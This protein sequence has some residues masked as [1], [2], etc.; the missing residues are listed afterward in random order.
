MVKTEKQKKIGKFRKKRVNSLKKN[1]RFIGGDDL[2]NETKD[3]I[4][5]LFYTVLVVGPVV[6]GANYGFPE[7]IKSFKQ[8]MEHFALLIR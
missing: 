7:T 2:T 5:I 4:R 3:N 8:L 1:K 6:V